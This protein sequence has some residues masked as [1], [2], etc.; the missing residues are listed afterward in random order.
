MSAAVVA[1]VLAASVVAV[2]VEAQPTHLAGRAMTVSVGTGGVQ[3]LA[4]AVVIVH[5]SGT[6]GRGLRHLFRKDSEDKVAAWVAEELQGRT[7]KS[8]EHRE[9]VLTLGA[10][11][12]P[13]TAYFS[14]V[15]LVIFK[16]VGG[17]LGTAVIVPKVHKTVFTITASPK[18]RIR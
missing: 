10:K 9:P 12:F 2:E 17:W 1:G 6:R 4:N 14:Q 3:E 7:Q 8:R 15:A 16:A 18:R 13:N 5:L 11:R